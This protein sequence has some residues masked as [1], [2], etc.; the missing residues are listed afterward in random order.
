YFERIL[1][2]MV[3]RPHS[4]YD[5]ECLL[6]EEERQ[7]L[8]GWNETRREYPRHQN[9]A[10]VFEE[11]AA[12]GAEAV[13]VVC[14]ERQLSYGELNRRA[15][16]LARY[17]RGAG[18]GAQE[19]VGIWQE[20]SAETVISMLAVVKAGGVYV[21]MESGSPLSRQGYMAADAGIGVMLAESGKRAAERWGGRRVIGVEEEGEEIGKQSGENLGQVIGAEELA[22]VI[23]TSGSTGRPKGVSVTHRGVL[24]LVCNNDYAELNSQQVIMHGSNVAFDA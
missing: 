9:L 16:Q 2:S 20:R 23:Y 19:C 7:V 3:L 13:A 24:R 14:E 15:N 4:R 12:R 18:V 6:S 1:K 21:P 17:L 11:Q 8:A 10:K 22:Y 5:D